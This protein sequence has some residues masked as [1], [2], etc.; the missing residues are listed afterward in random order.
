MS[1]RPVFVADCDAV[2]GAARFRLCERAFCR[3]HMMCYARHY[4][5]SGGLCARIDGPGGYEGAPRP[6]TTIGHI[7]DRMPSSTGRGLRRG[8]SDA[9]A[10]R[11]AYRAQLCT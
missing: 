11:A 3:K 2:G 9:A 5:N 4:C 8:A 7:F 6:L 1:S 10:A